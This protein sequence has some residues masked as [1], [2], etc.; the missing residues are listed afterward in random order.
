MDIKL[1]T[2][3]MNALFPEGNTWDDTYWGVCKGVGT[4]YLGK[5]LMIV[6]N[7][8]KAKNESI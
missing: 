4:N 6:R 1:D 2:K 7:D 5:L 8:L 3:A